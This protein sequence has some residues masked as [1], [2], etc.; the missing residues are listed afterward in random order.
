MT[1]DARFTPISPKGDILATAGLTQIKIWNLKT[2]E[3]LEVLSGCYPIVFSSNGE[4]LV[5]SN[6]D[7]NLIIWSTNIQNESSHIIDFVQ[8]WWKILGVHSDSSLLDVKTAYRLLARLYHPDLN[9]DPEAIVNMQIINY[10]YE[11]FLNQ[12]LPL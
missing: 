10:A 1:R 5:S 11:K 2:G 9:K 4:L 12:Y 8:E 7:N 3:L 6:K